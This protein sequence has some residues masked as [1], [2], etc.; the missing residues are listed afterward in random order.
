MVKMLVFMQSDMNYI[1]LF[2]V[3][4]LPI[5]I[6]SY[7]HKSTIPWHDN[8]AIVMKRGFSK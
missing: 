5:Q 4:F 8:V 2:L 1:R 7:R 6:V 3:S